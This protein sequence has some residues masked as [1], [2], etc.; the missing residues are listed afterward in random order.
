MRQA[1]SRA[2]LS[3]EGLAIGLRRGDAQFAMQPLL[4]LHNFV[5][6]IAQ[7]TQRFARRLRI[8]PSRFGELHPPGGAFE[9]ARPELLLQ[10]GYGLG[11]RRRGFP[12]LPGRPTEA[13]LLDHTNQG[14]ERVEFV[15][16]LL[17]KGTKVVPAPDVPLAQAPGYSQRETNKNKGIIHEAVHFESA[18]RSAGLCLS[19]IDG[20]S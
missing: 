15:H 18:R 10:S 5:A 6:G 9:Q 20:G 8:E 4:H 11:H 2:C 1:K 12:Q 3:Q 17:L 7:A 13:V 16:H 19:G 14:G